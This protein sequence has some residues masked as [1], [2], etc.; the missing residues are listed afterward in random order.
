[1]G[2]LVE[3]LLSLILAMTGIGRTVDP[4]L[5]AIANERV[6]E[7]Q[8]DWSHNQMR[9]G[10]W[11]VLAFNQRPTGEEA[12]RRA[13]EQWRGSPDH[14]AILSNPSL[15]RIGCSLDETEQTWWFV[16]VLTDTP[17]ASSPPPASSPSNSTSP[18]DTPTGASSLPDTALPPP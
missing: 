3:L 14:W 9:P 10:T 11:E 4:G 18:T 2:T 15:T 17:I 1:V 6:V 13:A 8:T 5:V 7:I 12:T 16:C